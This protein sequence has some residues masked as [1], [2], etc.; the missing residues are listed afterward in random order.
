MSL[1]TV[2]IPIYKADLS[3]LERKALEQ[4]YTVL[5]NHTITVIKPQSLDLS[6]LESEF[7][8]IELASFEDAYFKGISGYNKLMLSTA[9]YAYFRPNYQYILIYQ[10]DAYVFSDELTEWCNKGFDYVG[11]PWLKKPIYQLPVIKQFMRFVHWRK[12]RAGKP[13][14]QSFYNKIGNGGLSLR[15]VESHYQATLAHHQKID[16]YLSQERSHFYNEDVFWAMEVPEFKYPLPLEA[17][18]FAF[19]KYPA[20]CYK[21]NNQKLPMGCHAWYKRKMRKFWRPII[22]F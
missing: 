5:S 12:V 19:D 22:G 14:K 11:A 8:K 9:F 15:K 21:L 13:S 3:D 16:W 10:L 20:Y 1:V 7:P 4:A 2:V 17:I 18:K 6:K